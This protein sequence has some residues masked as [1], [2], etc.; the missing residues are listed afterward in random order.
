MNQA[1][2]IDMEVL[3]RIKFL[4]EY[5]VMKTS[6]ENIL[7]EQAS[8]VRPKQNLAGQPSPQ[9]KDM[10]AMGLNPKNPSDVEKYE[11]F[12]KTAYWPISQS[13]ELS[14]PDPTLGKPKTLDELTAEV[15]G[16]MSDWKVATVEAVIS[17]L[18]YGIPFVIAANAFWMTLELLQL[19]KGT[20]DWWS[21]VFSILATITAGSQ[22]AWLKPL[23]KLGGKGAKSLIGALD[24]LYQYAKSMTGGNNIGGFADDLVALIK[25]IPDGLSKLMGILDE[26]IEWISKLGPKFSQKG[27][28]GI[29]NIGVFLKDAKNWLSG[30]VKSIGDWVS[31]YINK[32]IYKAGRQAGIDPAT[33]RKLP[34]AVKWGSVPPGLAGTAAGVNYLLGPPELKMP[35]YEYVPG[36]FV[37]QDSKQTYVPAPMRVPGKYN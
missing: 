16:F 31:K 27:I 9:N 26:G 34:G 33:S 35:G 14:K 6:S 5:D 36:T 17:Y 22:A 23:Y 24:Q 28:E 12:A 21:L 13:V 19:K 8:M 20:P 32:P 10:E 18:G 11:K 7:L 29:A 3:Q 1:V 30:V 4:M 2:H 25:L 37:P 15:R